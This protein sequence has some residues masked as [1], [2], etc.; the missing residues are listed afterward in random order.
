MTKLKYSLVD[1]QKMSQA[2]IIQFIYL[3]HI[4]QTEHLGVWIVGPTDDEWF[5]DDHNHSLVVFF[6]V[7]FFFD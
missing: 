6:L 1:H 7:L 3:L 2:E 4:F 5:S